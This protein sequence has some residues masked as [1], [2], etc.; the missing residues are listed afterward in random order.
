MSKAI[1]TISLSNN[2]GNGANKNGRIGR[3]VG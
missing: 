1:C 3:I 2:L